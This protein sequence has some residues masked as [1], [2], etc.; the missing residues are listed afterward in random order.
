MECLFLV[1]GSSSV[2]V[3][4]G[5]VAGAGAV[6]GSRCSHGGGGGREEG[7]VAACCSYSGAAPIVVRPPLVLSSIIDFQ[8]FG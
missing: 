8:I 6:N 3:G 4:N 7:Y 5:S 1:P 2:G